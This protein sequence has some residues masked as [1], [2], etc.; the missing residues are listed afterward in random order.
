MIVCKRH[1][2]TRANLGY[3]RLPVIIE[4]KAFVLR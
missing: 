4:P 3:V 1:R 2:N